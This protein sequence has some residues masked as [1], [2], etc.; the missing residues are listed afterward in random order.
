M[1]FQVEV[2]TPARTGASLVV[3]NLSPAWFASVMGTGIFALTSK[4]YACYWPFLN[5]IAA[6]LWVLNI[7]L[8][9]A[10]LVPWTLRWLMYREC[11]LQD[12]KNP[13]TGQF[14]ATMPIG[15]LVLAADFLLIGKGFIGP[16]LA[17]YVAKYLWVAGAVLAL[18]MALII[19][20]IIFLNKVSI[21]DINPAWFMPPVSLIVVPIAG[22]KIIPYWP[23]FMQKVLL[24][25]NYMVWGIGFFLFIFLAVICFFR[26]IVAQPLPGPLIPTVWIYLGPV[27]A[28]TLA[29]LNMASVSTPFLGNTMV[30]A[31]KI[32]ALIYWSLG[33]WWLIVSSVVTITN[34][35]KKN[36][37]FALSWWAFTFPLGA[38][39]GATFLVSVNFQCDALKLYGLL[40]YCLLAFCW[41][42][43]VT[44]VILHA[45]T[46]FKNN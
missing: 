41:I 23:Q 10:L 16:V 32:F 39:T 17:I 28:G 37:P 13:V 1:S 15:C 42:A 33:F 4:Y 38:Y 29:L 8:F 12:L 34:A 31:L 27:G 19:P 44:G 9:L 2:A 7:V 46:L 30:Q 5:S 40:C 26:L 35:L 25:S 11:T 3:K 24:L 43:V 21:E 22:S 20:V 14:Y 45:G 36:L 6:C 18:V